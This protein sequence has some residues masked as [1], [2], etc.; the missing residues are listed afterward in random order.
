MNNIYNIKIKKES[1]RCDSNGNLSKLEHPVAF[2]D[3]LKNKLITFS[4][5]DKKLLINTPI[6]E[7]L[8][9][10]YIKLQEITDIV[11]LELFERN[12]L[13]WNSSSPCFDNEEKC[14]LTIEF[15]LNSKIYEIA[16]KNNIILPDN[17][18]DM[19]KN[20]V[21]KL[22][23]RISHFK[24]IFG[25]IKIEYNNNI[26]I[27]NITLNPMDRV[28]IEPKEIMYIIL[29][30]FSCLSDKVDLRDLNRIFS[31]RCKDFIENT[32]LNR[33]ENKLKGLTKK[34]LL[35]ILKNN[36]LEGYNER[37]RLKYHPKLLAE[38]A[39]LIKD[40]LSQG[41]DYKILNETTS[42]ALL[43]YEGHKEYIIEGNRTD[44]DSYIFPIVTDDKLVSKNIMKEKGLSVPDAILL[45][46]DMEQEE[47]EDLIKDLYSMPLVIKPRNTN[48][49]TGITVFSK[50]GTKDQ[51]NNAIK[52]AFEFDSDVL[53]EQYIK[54][55]E[56]RFLVVDGKCISVAH[57]RVASVV[58]D[59]KSTI[60]ELIDIKNKEPWHAL[61]GTPV[62]IEKPVEEF[63]KKS[64]YTYDTIPQKD[65]RVFLRTNS[66]CSTGGESLDVTN[67]I[68]QYFKEM[69]EKAA[70]AFNAKVCGVDLI[71]D[72][73]NKNDYSIIEINDDPGYSINEW[74]YEGKGEK[75]G[76]AILKLLGY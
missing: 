18:E 10:C 36:M 15:S 30:I 64:N 14:F 4:D 25:N 22:N 74:P 60:K 23:K 42:F 12:E 8:H 56:Y 39:I 68:P 13:L 38:A 75:V 47:I 50:P 33:N 48:M 26:T 20:I 49:G 72:D 11:I 7:D 35:D 31:L 61:T 54:G 21:N 41:I 57:R 43:D 3:R 51:I 65:E 45:T 34:E 2:G 6:C 52:Y 24:E 46:K 71:I 37:Y 27:N 73:L 29:E 32:Q 5:N 67:D 53:V 9:E 40:A 59:G 62:K 19:Y 55:K 1:L 28:G 66:N 17:I 16:E 63:L 69:S 76:L 58:G 44:R 70:N